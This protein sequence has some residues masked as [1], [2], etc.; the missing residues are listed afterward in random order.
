MMTVV[1]TLMNVTLVEQ[2][3]AQPCDMLY[4]R[5]SINTQLLARVDHLMKVCFF[6]LSNFCLL[7]MWIY[8]GCFLQVRPKKMASVS[9]Y[10]VIPTK[11]F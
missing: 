3:L 11:E 8:T 5:L 1:T 9:D 6:I 2:L 4:C 7:S 10:I